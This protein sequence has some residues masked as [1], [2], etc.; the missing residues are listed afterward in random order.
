MPAVFCGIDVGTQGAR[1]ALVR[2]D[3]QV[4]GQGESTFD[5]RT[6]ALPDGQSEQEPGAWTSAVKDAVGRARS[7]L[8]QRP[9]F[10]DRVAAVSVTGTSG[11]V[12]ALD[13]DHRPIV[14]ALMYND[15]RSAREAEQVQRA[16]R[17]VTARLGY[18]F[19]AS[20]ALPKV[21]WLK[22]RRPEVYARCALFL[23]PTDYII[24]WLT[25]SWPRT[26]QTNA[27]KWGYDLIE[28]RWPDFI[29]R[30]LGI[31]RALL[32]AVQKPGTEAGRV[33]PDRARELG[34]PSGTPVAA[35]MTDGC[36]SQVASGA[37]APGQYNTTIG[38][39]MVIKG[40]SDHLLLDPMG[41]IYCHRHPAGWWLPG[42]ASNTGAE[43][44]AVEFGPAETESRSARAL[45]HSPSD[46]VAY[47]LVGKGERFPFRAP[48]AERFLIGEPRGRDDLFAAYLEGVA[49]LERLAY[50]TLDD[51]GARVGQTILSAGGGSRSDAWLQI[52]ADTLNKRVARPAAAGAALGAA[53]VAAS[54]EEYTNLTEAVHAM[55]RIER[56][57]EPRPSL[58]GAYAAKY[59][60]FRQECV[61]RGY[62]PRPWPG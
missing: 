11:T 4:L 25:G 36:A 39:T 18:R 26:D 17:E 43:C 35:G 54:M 40:V 62:L 44:L 48:Q 31:A 49:C 56:E 45:D 34:L 10:A 27:L 28:D 46:L 14:P 7:S 57:V 41:R 42:G 20:F 22:R 3:G 29:E 2:A 9:P 61:N 21:L 58:T 51:L 13:A 19:G 23:S 59:E 12:C 5:A 15:S 37:V 33:T 1:C 16:G 50:D 32:P 6:A 60:R 52:R 47:P 53:I 38:T 24:G 55:V 8:D 30:D